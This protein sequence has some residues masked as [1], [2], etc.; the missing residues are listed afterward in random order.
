MG[1][2]R[3]RATKYAVVAIICTSLLIGLVC[4]AAILGLR[5]HF[6]IIFTSD[7]ELQRAV[8]NLA[9]LL[10]VTMVLNSVQP[11]ISGADGPGPVENSFAAQFLLHCG[12]EFLPLQ[13]SPWEGAGRP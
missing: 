13:G 10:A 12:P 1:S 2:G 8:A 7:V 11:V 9:Y 6:A 5:N 4:M 3:P